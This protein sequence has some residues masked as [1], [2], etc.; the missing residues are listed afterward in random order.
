[1]KKRKSLIL[2]LLLAAAA[3]WAQ[4]GQG[5]V[6]AL[7]DDRMVT[8][9][10][11]S[12]QATPMSFAAEE[13]R[14]NYVSGA[15]G[16]RSSYD[17]NIFGSTPQV[18]DVNYTLFPSIALQQS[19]SVLHWDLSYSPEFT[20]YQNHSS[21]NQVGQNFAASAEYR[22][23]PH[24][25][26]SANDAL[27]RTSNML[28]QFY[29]NPT[30]NTSGGAQGPPDTIIAPLA[31]RLSNVGSA[32]ITYQFALNGMVGASGTFSQLHY[33]NAEQ[34]PGFSDSSARSGK[35][36][37]AYRL[38]GKHYLGVSYWF[39]DL[40]SHPGNAAQTNSVILFY[41]LYLN[42]TSSVAV[43]AGPEHSATSGIGSSPFAMWSPAAGGS[44][45]W[46]STHTSFS[47]TVSRRVTEGGGLPEAV[48]S[49][50]AEAS[51]RRQLTRT[52]TVAFSG[53]YAQN[54]YLQSLASSGTGGHTVSMNASIS[55]TLGQHL[56]LQL[57][58]TRLEQNY[59]NLSAAAS[60]NRNHVWATLSY[61]FERPLGR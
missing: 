60:G 50:S 23:S 18:H 42:T 38:S 61:R 32:Q 49:E 59:G 20:F 46:Q 57:S 14:A 3:A 17:D 34:A 44:F 12:T 48:L 11:V 27:I 56:G 5:P 9:T 52:C 47:T 43:F 45:G 31:D 4:E 6:P 26:L 39:Q 29:Q 36:F 21:Y 54:T 13:P 37:Y 7:I 16:F 51:M 1:M 24:V 25:T 28:G 33:L 2:A 19:R 30:N 58:Y 55:R 53:S 15:I 40:L 22:L 35:A 10:P 8:P 41:T